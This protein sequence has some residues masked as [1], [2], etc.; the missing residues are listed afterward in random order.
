MVILVL[1]CGS[2]SIKYQVID[3]CDAAHTLL[4]KG[5]VERIGLAEGDLTHKPVGKEVFKLHQPIADHTTGIRLVLD[6]LTNPEHGVISSLDE[7]KAVGHRV[8]HGGEFFASSCIVTDEVKEKIRSL[9]DI[10]PLHNPANLEGILSIEKV[11]PEVKQ[12][13]VFDTSFHQSI[14]PINY[15]CALPY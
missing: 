4:A 12:V 7:V 14:E 9:F 13:A 10:A 15:L 11:L 1:N 8:A 3:I 5:L 2:S 6:A